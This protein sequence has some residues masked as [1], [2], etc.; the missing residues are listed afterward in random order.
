[1]IFIQLFGKII[2]VL[3]AGPSPGQIAA[4][5]V[6]GMFLGMM[7]VT[8]LY[9]IL[10]ILLIFLLNV[11][12]SA[13]LLG[14]MVFTLFSFVLDP[15]FHNAGYTILTQTDLLTGFWT[16]LYNLPLIPLF[17]FNNTVVLGSFVFSLIFAIPVFFLFRTG[18]I[19]YRISLEPRIQKLK[20]VHIIRTNKIYRSYQKITQL[21]E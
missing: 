3:R 9:S 7:P 16:K 20:I 6:L 4:G 12:I 13:S 14:W 8:N 11:N 10:I 5:F 2:K 17:K 18:V 15:L 21:R 1:V 19:H